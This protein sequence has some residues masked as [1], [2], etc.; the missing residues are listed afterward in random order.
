[1]RP[2][3]IQFM[4]ALGRSGEKFRK[5]ARAI[6]MTSTSECRAQIE[7]AAARLLK[8]EELKVLVAESILL[9]LIDQGWKVVSSGPEIQLEGPGVESDN[10]SEMKDRVRNAHLIERNVY[11]RQAPVQDFITSMEQRR[12]TA[13]GWHSIFSLMR[14]GRELGGQLRGAILN[15]RTPLREEDLNNIID[16]YIEFVELGSVCEHTGLTL[17]DIW[18]YF[19]LTWVN[20]PKSVPGR[21]M[22]I[23][24]RDRAAPNHPVIGIAA[25]SSSVVQQQL[26]DRWIGWDAEVFT[27][28]LRT[29]PSTKLGKK[30]L[31]SIDEHIG[32]LYIADLVA[33]GIITRRE[34]R[35]P[36]SLGIEHLK[37]EGAQARRAH[38][39]YPR[40]A[41]HKRLLGNWLA[42]AQTDLF[43]FKRCETLAKLLNIRRAF[44]DAGVTTGSRAQLSLACQQATFQNAVGQL[45][46][47]TKSEHIGIDM[48][49]ITVCGA[50][51]PYTH[52]LGGKLVCA[53]LFSPEVVQHYRQ[54]YGDQESVI[55]S[56]MQGASVLRSPR[57]VLLGTTSLYGIGSSQYNRIRIPLRELGGTDGEVLKYEELGLSKGYGSFHVS[58][59]TVRLIGKLLARRVEGRRV[60]S[61]FGEGVNPLMRKIR[62][63]FELLRLP[64][65]ALL[66]HGNRRVVYG[67]PLARNFRDVLIGLADRPSYFLSMAR[68]TE[69]TKAL[70]VFW[71]KRWLAPRITRAGVL[72]AVETHSLAFPVTHGAR[73]T[74]IPENVEDA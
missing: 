28:N 58:V 14:D 53:L 1:M 16:P 23:L 10:P 11:L 12:L 44:L 65:D 36:T 7:C 61:I 37:E 70:A 38:Q 71:R 31:A 60:N 50:I 35:S 27:N 21:S 46:R 8:R 39:L 26:R 24:I 62:E 6:S 64:S 9:D 19:R 52:I 55:A 5:F 74:V 72:E 4:P 32:S 66:L 34:I 41:E 22:T 73:V 67:V 42:A 43:R 68:P 57:L 51:P 20:A 2:A 40:V 18:R 59:T 25:L 48:M 17:S 49:D 33:D 30:L 45:V 56:S 13:K 63:A 29:K 3:P 69:E 15:E 47:L 54:R